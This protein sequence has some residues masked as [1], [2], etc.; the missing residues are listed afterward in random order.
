[1]VK[2]TH[3]DRQDPP[4]ASVLDNSQAVCPSSLLQQFET[5]LTLKT[6]RSRGSFGKQ[7]IMIATLKKFI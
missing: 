6:L 5:Q 1:M 3:R 7:S 2:N 4:I